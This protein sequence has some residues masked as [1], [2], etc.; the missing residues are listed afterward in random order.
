MCQ[1]LPTISGPLIHRRPLVPQ[2]IFIEPDFLR[3]LAQRLCSN[4]CHLQPPLALLKSSNLKGTV[5]SLT[6][7]GTPFLMILICLILIFNISHYSFL[8]K[9]FFLHLLIL[10][11]VNFYLKWAS[12]FVTRQDL[13]P[14]H[15]WQRTWLKLEYVL[16]MTW[17]HPWRGCNL[18]GCFLL[19]GKAPVSVCACSE[20][21]CMQTYIVYR[22]SENL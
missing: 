11:N 1:T 4:S 22:R 19:R 13:L 10:F 17:A 8:E 20:G 18:V 6:T 9:I 21:Y 7:C 16:S 12:I 5:V 14:P 15:R 3:P 2:F